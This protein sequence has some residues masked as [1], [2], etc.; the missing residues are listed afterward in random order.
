MTGFLKVDGTHQENHSNFSIKMGR[1]LRIT[2][3]YFMI[4]VFCRFYTSVLLLYVFLESYQF[5]LYSKF[6]D[7]K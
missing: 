4:I 5:H 7:V 3:T 2:S 6:D 1:S